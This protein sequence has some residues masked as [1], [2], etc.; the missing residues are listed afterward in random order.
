[1]RT[2]VPGISDRARGFTLLETLAVLAILGVVVG[3]LMVSLAPAEARTDTASVR[4]TAGAR[5]PAEARRGEAGCRASGT[6]RAQPRRRGRARPRRGHCAR[7]GWRRDG[8]SGGPRALR[9][10]DGDVAARGPSRG[11]RVGR[12]AGAPA[13]PCTVATAR[14]GRRRRGPHWRVCR[15]RRSCLGGTPS[16]PRAAAREGG[17]PGRHRCERGVR[18]VGLER[19]AFG[20]GPRRAAALH[21]AGPGARSPP[22]RVRG[23][24]RRSGRAA[25]HT[26]FA[27]AWRAS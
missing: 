7:R 9:E 8:C 2:S 5:A 12:T 22:A 25:R 18:C 3:T 1:M 11:R 21:G 17:G 23:G 24:H 6:P 16:G 26:R 14:D 10:G 15:C 19:C 13:R 4:S 27:R 20:A